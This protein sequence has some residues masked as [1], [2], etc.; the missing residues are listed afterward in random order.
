MRRWTTRIVALALLASAV[1]GAAFDFTPPPPAAVLQFE[2]RVILAEVARRMDVRLRPEIAVPPVL[3][4]SLT[5]LAQLQDAVQAQWGIRPHV[6]ANVYVVARNEI[7]LIDDAAYYARLG[8]TI[9]DSLAHEFV[10]Y[11]Q[12]KYLG[13]DLA[14]PWL[15][16][17]AVQ[18]Q[19]AFQ[20]DFA[21]LP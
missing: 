21:G 2:P 10:H 4:E 9:D 8:T 16:H 14:E 15:E 20:R 19:L 17:A 11:L 12:S 6:F 5:P 7:Y 13:Y 18:I 3:L 1:P